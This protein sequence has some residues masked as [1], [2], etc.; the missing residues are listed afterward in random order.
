MLNQS[1]R[2]YKNQ[3]IEK[4]SPKDKISSDHLKL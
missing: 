1:L 3:N 4:Y 2:D